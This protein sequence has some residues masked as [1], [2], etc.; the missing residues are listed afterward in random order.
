M[1]ITYT[2]D[3]NVVHTLNGIP[4]VKADQTSHLGHF[5]GNNSDCRN[6][7]QGV[8]IQLPV[9]TLCYQ[10]LISAHRM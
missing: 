6:V 10:N 5:I 3:G 2:V 4:I 9:I 7:S 8:S 1:L